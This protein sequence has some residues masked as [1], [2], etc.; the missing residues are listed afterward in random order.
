[1]AEL[2]WIEGGNERWKARRGD[3]GEVAVSEEEERRWKSD[4]GG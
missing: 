4:G 2:P 3:D 1:M